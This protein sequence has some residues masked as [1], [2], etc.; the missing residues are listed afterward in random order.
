MA[1]AEHVE[2]H[3]FH[4]AENGPLVNLVSVDGSSF[5]VNHETLAKSSSVFKDMLELPS[6]QQDRTES[7]HPTQSVPIEEVDRWDLEHFVNILKVSQPH[8]PNTNLRETMTLF[9]LCKKYDITAAKTSKIREYLLTLGKKQPWEFLQ[10]ASHA[11]EQEL[12]EIALGYLTW[13]QFLLGDQGDKTSFWGRI[14]SLSPEWRTYVLENTLG[15][16]KDHSLSFDSDLPG[17]DRKLRDRYWQK[18][19]DSR[20]SKILVEERIWRAWWSFLKWGALS[21]PLLIS[22]M[23]FRANMKRAFRA[24]IQGW[25]KYGFGTMMTYMAIRWYLRASKS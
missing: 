15:D 8:T 9:L 19:M 12:C 1:P 21:A 17:F 4:R 11:N 20:L 5:S 13:N 3:P 18:I 10:V 7:L 6:P 2:I 16:P 23:F 14:E 25:R 22:A 24:M